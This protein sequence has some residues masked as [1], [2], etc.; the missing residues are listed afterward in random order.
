MS[1]CRQR[2]LCLLF[3]LHT[4][5]RCRSVYCLSSAALVVHASEGAQSLE[6]FIAH[7]RAR[8]VSRPGQPCR[9]QPGTGTLSFLHI[10]MSLKQRLPLK[11]HSKQ[12]PSASRG[13]QTPSCTLYTSAVPRG[14]HEPP[15]RSIPVPRY[16]YHGSCGIYVIDLRIRG[17][18]GAG[19]RFQSSMRC[20]LLVVLPSRA[21]CSMQY[22]WYA[23]TKHPQSAYEESYHNTPH[24]AATWQRESAIA[25][26]IWLSRVWFEVSYQYWLSTFS[27]TT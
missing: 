18:Y 25:A 7:N 4:V 20:D 22:V 19:D 27:F 10:L 13:R 3:L 1:L 2:V 6:R 8:R 5:D 21:L 16:T 26:R 12:H 9:R 11:T 24:T 17:S 23:C 15:R 14:L